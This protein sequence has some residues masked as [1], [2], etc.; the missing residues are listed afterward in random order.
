M[1][2]GTRVKPR[3]GLL[4]FKC[5]FQ[6][7]SPRCEGKNRLTM[8]FF[9]PQTRQILLG[10][11]NVNAVRPSGTS[12]THA[13]VRTCNARMLEL[14]ISFH[15]KVTVSEAPEVGGMSP[16]HVAALIGDIKLAQLL[17]NNGAMTT[18]QVTPPPRVNMG[19]FGF[20]G[21]RP[22]RCNPLQVAEAASTCRMHR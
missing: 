11:G 3:F 20:C 13:A 8:P 21:S 14:V 19:A 1:Q 16:L 4:D 17:L 9:T 12:L 15:P 22:N 5:R 6:V 2:Q 10:D 18:C 7:V